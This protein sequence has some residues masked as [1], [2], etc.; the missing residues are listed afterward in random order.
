MT[1]TV[2]FQN[3]LLLAM[4]ALADPNFHHSVTYLCEHNE[5]GAIGIMINRPTTISLA[6][7]LADMK[8]T[9]T[10][11]ESVSRI[12]VLFGG[13]V[14]QE[15]GFVIHRPTGKWRATLSTGTDIA[16][17]TSRDIL[18]AM[19]Q[20][21][22]PTD[23]IIALGCAAWEAGQLEHEI[24]ENS[25]LTVPADPEVIYS[26]PFEQRWIAAAARIGVDFN[27]MSSEV[28]HG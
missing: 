27:N 22:G 24:H 8:I 20:H 13:P 3:N 18:E 26:T 14:H 16:I 7:V 17:T 5:N 4:P 15:R 21:G 2:Y 28:G 1:E 10:D 25:W 23:V 19:A 6:D 11:M 12:P 9:T